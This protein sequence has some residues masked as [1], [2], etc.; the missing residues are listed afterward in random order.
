MTPLRVKICGL[1]QIEHAQAAV[2]AGADLI[3]FVFAPV[4]RYVAPETAAAIAREVPASVKKVGLFVNAPS[5]TVRS[6]VE[7]CGLDYA[8]LC[9][10]ETPEFCRALGLPVVRSLRVRG[11]DIVDEVERFAPHVSWCILD[12]FQP[13]A[14]GGTGTSFDWRLAQTIAR[15]YPIMVA[16]GLTPETVG[17][18]IRLVA[19]LGVD[20]SSGVETDGAKDVLKIARFIAA[21]RAAEREVS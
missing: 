6:I 15:Q 19:P 5:D 2:E 9:G 3:G 11:P 14:Y 7:Q 12:G 18:A 4:R 8:Q 1:R 13:N 16:G 17:E 20:V 21:A 10:D